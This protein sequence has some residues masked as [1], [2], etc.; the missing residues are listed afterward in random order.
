MLKLKRENEATWSISQ[1]TEL[2]KIVL[3]A[4]EGISFF[5]LK[6]EPSLSSVGNDL[7]V[8]EPPS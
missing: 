3:A 1:E 7:P 4:R 2:E 8:V 6:R 5:A